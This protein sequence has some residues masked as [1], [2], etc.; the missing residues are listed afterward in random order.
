MC[1][2]PTVKGGLSELILPLPNEVIRRKYYV[3]KSTAIFHS[4]FL[5]EAITAPLGLR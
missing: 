4:K 3:F 5:F 1:L 2:R